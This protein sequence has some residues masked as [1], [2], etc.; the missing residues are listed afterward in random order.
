MLWSCEEVL[1]VMKP[2]YIR[3]RQQSKLHQQNLSKY[4]F[5]LNKLQND[6]S[7]GSS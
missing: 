6:Y 1:R 4:G 7:D 3:M 5:I 2:H